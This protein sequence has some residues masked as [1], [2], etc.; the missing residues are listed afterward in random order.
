MC[1]F[2]AVGDNWGRQFPN[3]YPWVQPYIPDPYPLPNPYTPPT[4]ITTVTISGVSQEEFDRLKREVE[5]LRELLLAAKKFDEETGQPDCQ[6]DDKVDLIRKV[7]K[8][9]GV[10]V[11]EVF[12]K[13]E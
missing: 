12:G 9:V 7:A 8:L 10:D 13:D 3:R 4:P 1:M 2:S 11:D 5:D 6:D